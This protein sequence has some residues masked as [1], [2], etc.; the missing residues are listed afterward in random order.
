[1]IRRPPRSTLFPYTT[2]FRSVY[3]SIEKDLISLWKEQLL[4]IQAKKL[5]I[6]KNESLRML[7]K[8]KSHCISEREKK[9]Y[10][11][12]ENYHKQAVKFNKIFNKIT[13]IFSK[14]QI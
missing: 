6:A 5:K 14:V 13:K 10:K 12:I 9:I 7:I 8:Y 1:M 3:L 2:L 11:N 4:S